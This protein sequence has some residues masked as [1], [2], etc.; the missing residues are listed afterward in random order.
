[1]T[2]RIAGLL[3][4]IATAAGPTRT[5]LIDVPAAELPE[6]E[7]LAGRSVELRLPARRSERSR[8][9]APARRPLTL[10]L[11]RDTLDALADLVSAEGVPPSEWVEGL[12]R[13]KLG[14]E[15]TEAAP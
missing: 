8:P 10:H 1:M 2:G 3:P 5:L 11:D 6:G 14:T 12:I 13:G 15:A 4:P 7:E 9:E